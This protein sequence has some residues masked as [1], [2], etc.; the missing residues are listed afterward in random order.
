MQPAE[1]LGDVHE[2]EKYDRKAW[3]LSLFKAQ[4]GRRDAFMDEDEG[5]RAAFAKLP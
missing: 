3:W 2:I 5:D 4:R 1:V